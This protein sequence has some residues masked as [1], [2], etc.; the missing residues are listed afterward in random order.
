MILALTLTGCATA[1]QPKTEVPTLPPSLAPMTTASISPTPDAVTCDT[2]LTADFYAKIA[3]DGLS[4][5]ETS[6]SS[7]AD[8]LVGT[9]GVRCR[10]TKPQTDITAGYASW[11]R[12]VDVWESLKI[13]LFTDGYVETGQVVVGRPMSEFDSA[14]SYRDGVIHYASPSQFIGWVTALQ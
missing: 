10:W 4:I 5:L 11:S 12:D 9:D 8:K 2:A 14:Y 1:A 3:E 6:F 7:D 13:E